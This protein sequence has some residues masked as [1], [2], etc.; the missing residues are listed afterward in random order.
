MYY[1]YFLLLD[2]A[3]VYKGFTEDLK[4][5]I[6]EQKRGKVKSTSKYKD[7]KLIGYDA[8]L[9]KS[10]AQRREKFS[11]TSDGRKLFKQQYRN[12]LNQFEVV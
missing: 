12:I 9:L 11:K 8:Y 5:R 1:V 6:G 3:V 7:I 2:R 10:D 4:R